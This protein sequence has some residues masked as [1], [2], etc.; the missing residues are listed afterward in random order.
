MNIVPRRMYLDSIFDDFLK[1]D[2][3]EVMKCDIYEKDGNYYLEADIPGF[4]KN[5]IKIDLNDGSLPITASKED[6]NDENDRNYIKKERVSTQ[7]QRQFYVGDVEAE[8]IKAEFNNGI[9]KIT[10]PEQE[11]PK[12]NHSINID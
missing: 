5:A 7:I 12:N 10:I 6:S 8:E 11:K 1:N 2:N 9:L 4:S 3:L